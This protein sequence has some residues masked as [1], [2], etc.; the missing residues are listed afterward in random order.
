LGRSMGGLTTKFHAAVSSCGRLL[1]GFLT[2]GQTA[3]AKMGVLLRRSVAALAPAGVCADRAYDSAKIRAQIEEMGAEAVIPSR[4]GRL[5]KIPHD[6]KK[7]KERNKAERYFGRLKNWRKIILRTDKLAVACLSWIWLI[8]A[9]EWLG[10]G[11]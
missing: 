3:D 5:V 2:P 10:P 1:S 9:L 11:F 7:Y 4:S 8:S 6:E